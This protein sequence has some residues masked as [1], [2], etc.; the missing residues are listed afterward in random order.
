MLQPDKVV[1]EGPVVSVGN[2]AAVAAGSETFQTKIVENNKRQI[3]I[4]NDTL[5]QLSDG[6]ARP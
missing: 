1:W 6:R 3:D 4:H 5:E 2:L